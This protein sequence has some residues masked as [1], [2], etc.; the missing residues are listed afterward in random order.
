MTTKKD[1]GFFPTEDYKIPVTKDYLNK[2][3]QGDTTFRI[4]SSAI[5]G[6]VYFNKDNKPIRSRDMFEGTPEDIKK[7]GTVKH[8]WA[9]VIWNYND[10]RIQILEITQKSIMTPMKA[11]IENPKWGNPKNYDITISRKGTT[12][13]D[14]EYAVM[15]NPK[16]EITEEVKTAYESKTINLD[17]LFTGED[18]FKN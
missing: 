7:D 1:D 18:P 11:L 2:F 17:V 3:E 9:C 6:Y 14:T 12:M 13:N 10:E 8:F 5:I 15:P 16:A 4:L